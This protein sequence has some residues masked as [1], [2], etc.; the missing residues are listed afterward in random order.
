MSTIT[1]KELTKDAV[2]YAVNEFNSIIVHPDVFHY[3]P[4]KPL[5]QLKVIIRERKPPE[6]GVIFTMKLVT[7]EGFDTESNVGSVI[8]NTFK[9]TNDILDK[10]D[11]ITEEF[12]QKNF[13]YMA[14]NIFWIDGNGSNTYMNIIAKAIGVHRDNIRIFSSAN[15]GIYEADYIMSICKWTGL[16][17]I[18]IISILDNKIGVRL[19]EKLKMLPPP[20]GSVM[21]VIH[22]DVFT[23]K[24]S[25]AIKRKNC[26]DIPVAIKFNRVTDEYDIEEEGD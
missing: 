24:S 6:N 4:V 13:Y 2:V 17:K 1:L 10:A 7:D 8:Y 19:S 18:N 20:S 25:C 11:D 26:E 5:L 12:C 23:G 15:E 22:A 21:V 3:T 14:T 16:T 9:C